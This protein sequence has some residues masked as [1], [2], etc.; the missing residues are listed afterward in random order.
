MTEVLGKIEGT[1][2]G[3]DCTPEQRQEI[4][5]IIEQVRQPYTLPQRSSCL[6]RRTPPGWMPPA[7]ASRRT[8]VS[9]KS[10]PTQDTTEHAILSVFPAGSAL[11]RPFV[12]VCVWLSWPV[13][14]VRIG[15]VDKQKRQM[16]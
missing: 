14:T 8:V 10:V 2:R 15:C 7:L 11:A 4:D 3:I 13:S 1:N 5:G 12:S 9:E 6:N 16:E